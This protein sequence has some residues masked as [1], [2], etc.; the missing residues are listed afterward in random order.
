MG[1][2]RPGPDATYGLDKPALKLSVRKPS[3]QSRLTV[4]PAKAEE[5]LKAMKEL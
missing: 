2:A 1:A 3:S 5:R 4:D